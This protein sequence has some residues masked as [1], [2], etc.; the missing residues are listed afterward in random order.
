MYNQQSYHTANY[1][2]NIQGHDR[3]LRSDSQQPSSNSMQSS[4]YEASSYNTP[5][6][7]QYRGSQRTFQP[8]GF[9]QS[10][11]GQGGQQALSSS[12]AG[13]QYQSPASY[14]M[15]N[16]RGNQPGQTITCALIHS[17]RAAMEVTEAMGIP[18]I[19]GTMGAPR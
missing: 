15:S 8:T 13:S 7:S 12:S 10:V 9:V 16:Y 4:G 3:Y 18:G 17:S 2:G 19:M 14:H 11:Y 1:R 6:T 5:V